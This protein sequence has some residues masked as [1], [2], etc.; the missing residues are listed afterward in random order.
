MLDGQT[1]RGSV[2]KKIYLWPGGIIP[3]VLESSLSTYTFACQLV[4][5]KLF[6][7]RFRPVEA[8]QTERCW[9]TLY[10]T[11]HIIPLALITIQW[12]GTGAETPCGEKRDTRVFDSGHEKLRS[13]YTFT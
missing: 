12:W 4:Y 6:W 10:P 1:S 9:V 5:K 13:A 7:F 11:G 8:E 3:Y 2:N